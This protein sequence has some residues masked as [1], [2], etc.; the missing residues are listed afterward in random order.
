MSP[1]SASLRPFAALV[2]GALALAAGIAL[3][4]AWLPEWLAGPLPDERFFSGRYRALARQAGIR[5]PS[6]EPRMALAG[7]DKDMKLDDDV[8]D[9]LGPRRAAQA[10]AG[11]LVEVKQEGALPGGG[12]GPKEFLVRFLPSGYPLVIRWSN[13]AEIVKDSLKKEP[14][15]SAAEQARFS[16]L[17][18]RSGESFGPAGQRKAG[19]IPTKVTVG[20][21][22]RGAAFREGD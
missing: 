2:L 8:M 19:G 18:L 15:P 21:E 13:Q 14:A 20:K 12:K 22:N 9:R 1:R 4:R 11:L 6:D 10:G 16:R 3:A 7:R 5:L 17:L